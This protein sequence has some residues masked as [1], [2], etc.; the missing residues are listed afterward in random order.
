MGRGYV[1]AVD[2]LAAAE[3]WKAVEN[4]GNGNTNLIVAQATQPNRGFGYNYILQ[5]ATYRLTEFGPSEVRA[6]SVLD[7]P[8]D[9]LVP[10]AFAPTVQKEL[11]AFNMGPRF[12]GKLDFFDGDNNGSDDRVLSRTPFAPAGFALDVRTTQQQSRD[13][14]VVLGLNRLWLFNVTNPAQPTQYSS[15]SFAELGLNE[16]NAPLRMEVEGTIAYILFRNKVA[17]I[18][19]S[20]PEHPA[21]ATTIT[22]IGADVR[23]LAVKDGFVY[24]LAGDTGVKVSIGRTAS[25]SFAYGSG[26]VSPEPG[27]PPTPPTCAYPVLLKRADNRMAQPAEVFFQVFGQDLARSAEVKIYKETVVNDVPE[28]RLLTTVSAT[29]HQASNSRIATGTAQWTSSDP[30]DQT[31]RYSAEISMI[32]G[33]PN[34]TSIY[35]GRRT[36]IPFSYLLQAPSQMQMTVNGLQATANDKTLYRYALGS[37]A[38]VHLTV[39]GTEIT[40]DSF[41]R[42]VNENFEEVR[43]PGTATGRYPFS[44]NA[45]RRPKW[46]APGVSSRLK[47]RAG[48]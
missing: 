32:Y 22:G 26:S 36:P 24:S 40:A 45:W 9:G 43:L 12:D 37:P 1:L 34:A 4:S 30:I 16:V 2:Y 6:V 13:L 29:L 23:A 25:L 47:A 20:D 11:A 18:D 31:A 33:P 7:Q 5:R 15:K 8:L 41:A 39:N 44:I 42:E 38:N 14:A 21:L 27:Q 3:Y 10:V 35:R 48:W 17:V 46:A 19:F 28:E